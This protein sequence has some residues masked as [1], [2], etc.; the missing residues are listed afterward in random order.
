MRAGAYVPALFVVL[1]PWQA[2]AFVAGQRGLFCPYVA[3]G[4]VI[5]GVRA[6]LSTMR[7]RII[8]ATAGSPGG[9]QVPGN[10]HRL[11]DEVWARDGVTF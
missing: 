3:A 10:S 7:T 1:P 9:R 4:D 11:R 6:V 2:I 5:A 8:G